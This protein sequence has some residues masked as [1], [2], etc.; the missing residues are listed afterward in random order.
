MHA[1][2][3]EPPSALYYLRQGLSVIPLE[4]RDKRPSTRWLP[5]GK[6]TPY[7]T[8][9]ATE[10]V[11][12]QWDED[13]S[14]LN[15]GVICGRISD[16]ACCGDIDSMAFSEWVLANPRRAIFQGACIVRTGSGKAHIWFRCNNPVISG[17]W[18]LG[19]GHIG[20]IRGDGRDG[21][22]G[23][24][25]AVPPSVH[26]TG[27]PYE[28][29]AGDFDSLPVVP[30][31]RAF[32][33]G[34]ARA[35]RDAAPDEAPVE[36]KPTDRRIL[37]ADDD[38]KA[39]ALASLKGIQLKRKILDTLFTPGHQS[40]DSPHWARTNPNADFSYSEIDFAVVADLSRKGLTFEQIED[41]FA[42]TLVGDACYRNKDRSNHGRSYLL[43][44][45]ENVQKRLTEEVTAQG[46]AVGDNFKVTEAA[47]LHQG[48]KGA[49]YLLSMTFIEHDGS[50]VKVRC[51]VAH[52]DLLVERRFQ[53]VV[54]GQV[55]LVP[56][57]GANFKGAHFPKFA[58]AV[59]RMVSD[60]RQ[61]PLAMTREGRLAEWL[62]G[63]LVHL[64]TRLPDVRGAAD[65][66]GWTY[67]GEAHLRVLGL[68]DMLQ[69]RDRSFEPGEVRVVLDLLGG[70]HTVRHLWPDGY[71]EPVIRLRLDRRPET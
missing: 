57:V 54:F 38:R 35:W 21:G 61:T 16:G 36:P 49:L 30:D 27:V 56:E 48:R 13:T 14:H 63:R 41:V 6:W 69:S 25:A 4:P 33:M 52:K 39:T 11:V 67:E 19:D 43:T 50:S 31:G 53:E 2:D 62:R 8:M 55:H 12:R 20:D 60:E 66:L 34:I 42:C 22:G 64:P 32:L 10:A 26:P 45:W 40:P 59:A 37:D 7:Q 47:R 68:I 18:R 3:M 1:P 46:L 70:H 29:V 15:L 51:E 24:Y 28:F 23:S 71:S 9:R 58:K 17:K 65:S 44:T 5:N